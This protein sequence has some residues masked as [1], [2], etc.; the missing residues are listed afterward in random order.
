MSRI[1]CRRKDQ[2]KI[3]LR[4]D[5][6]DNSSSIH[7]PLLFVANAF[8]SVANTFSENQFL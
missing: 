5:G 3:F 8:F 1:Y 4:K 2:S 7:L 6:R